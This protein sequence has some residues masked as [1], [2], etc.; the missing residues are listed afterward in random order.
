[1]S[2]ASEIIVLCED[3]LQEVFVRRFLKRGWGIKEPP[4]RVITPPRSGSA[5]AGEKY[6]RDNY[7]SQLKAC[8]TRHA[9]TILIVGID[10]DR[11]TVSAHHRE[12]DDACRQAQPEV[13]AR[14]ANEA[15][16]HVI[17]KWHIETWLAYLNGERVS[18]DQQYK[19]SYA[20]KGCEAKCH[21]LIDKLAAACKNG[22][23]LADPP[24]SLVQAC[25]EFDRI[26]GL[27]QRQ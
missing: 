15:V 11:R 14:Q 24:D 6:V 12:L 17:P 25:G 18:E 8:R 23:R 13:T 27:L 16:V 1:M 9:R 2:R 26:R 19:S 20:F 3:R 7:A 10:A 4:L 22:E 21:P 5:G